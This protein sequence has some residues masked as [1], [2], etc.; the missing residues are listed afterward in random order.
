MFSL[1]RYFVMIHRRDRK[2]FQLEYI[3]Y[4]VIHDSLHSGWISPPHFL[5]VFQLRSDGLALEWDL[6]FCLAK[7]AYIGSLG[8]K[9]EPRH[10][11]LD[12]GD[13]SKT[14]SMWRCVQL[15]S[16]VNAEGTVFLIRSYG[17]SCEI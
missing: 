11:F 2:S 5:S 1:Y 15:V 7:L 16:S 9:V 8:L 13:D 4:A 17:A 14:N 12:F 3:R 6:F 10:I